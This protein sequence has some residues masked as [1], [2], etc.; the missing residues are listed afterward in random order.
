[1]IRRL[2]VLLLL[3]ATPALAQNP[4]QQPAYLAITGGVRTE[5]IPVTKFVDTFNSPT[6]LDTTNNWNV[7]T[8]SGT[9]SATYTQGQEVLSSGTTTGSYAL[10]TSQTTFQI[11]SPAYLVY[12]GA[13]NGDASY[14][15]TNCKEMGFFIAAATPTCA[16][17]VTDGVLFEITS[18][19]TSGNPGAGKLQAV[20]YAGGTRTLIADLSTAVSGITYQPIFNPDGTT[21]ICPGRNTPQPFDT[22][23]HILDIWFNGNSAEFD[24]DGKPVGFM[25]NG[26]L[27]P[28]NN[29]LPWSSLV[30]NGGGTTASTL[31]VNQSAVGDEG[32]NSNK[33]CDPVYPWR[34]VNVNSAGA[35]STSGTLSGT[36]SNASSGVATGATNVP[37]VSYN[38]AWNGTTWDQL[39]V[40]RGDGQATTGVLASMGVLVNGAS[41]DR[42]RSI[43]G[44][45]AAGTGT[46]A[47]AIAPTSAASGGITS[48]VSG[49]AENNHVLKAS[50]GNLYSVYAT[51]LTATGG[52]LVILNS[53][54]APGDGAITPL[55]CVPLPANGNAT[56]NYNPGP[57]AV[58]STGIT[59]VLT[60]ATTCFTKTTGTITGFI[61]GSI[62]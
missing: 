18:T 12:R 36:T 14:V 1:M 49:A 22:C 42:V 35:L 56:V 17:P 26:S 28:N 10:L 55:E 62:Q 8:T 2:I 52:F 7:P 53:T 4:T 51:N 31:K 3:C 9:G 6:T 59:A 38:Y 45:L 47:V 40:T 32:R 61:K 21:L 34:C 39:T 43:N 30:I 46:T 44:A 13:I 19:T 15:T 24:V 60:S 11:N 25:L 29:A 37:T 58:F 16:A 33:I 54:T 41:L 23:P 50:A 5:G 20:T 48:V 27:G 57:P